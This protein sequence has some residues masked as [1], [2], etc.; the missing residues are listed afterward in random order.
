MPLSDL[1]Q[2]VGKHSVIQLSAALLKR[3]VLNNEAG[4]K[5]NPET[6][7]Y[8]IIFSLFYGVENDE[9]QVIAKSL[10][11]KEGSLQKLILKFLIEVLNGGN[12][13]ILQ[14]CNV[15]IGKV[16]ENKYSGAVDNSRAKS[17][18]GDLL[19][20][21][22]LDL[23]SSEKQKTSPILGDNLISNLT[24]DKTQ[25]F[26]LT[27]VK[28]FAHSYEFIDIDFRLSN[29]DLQ[30]Y[31]TMAT[32]LAQY[33]EYSNLSL[34][35]SDKK[36][37]KDQTFKEAYFEHMRFV[38]R[39]TNEVYTIIETDESTLGPSDLSL[40]RFFYIS[41]FL[42]QTEY[43]RSISL[44]FTSSSVF[45][46]EILNKDQMFDILINERVKQ[47]LKKIDPP[48]DTVWNKINTFFNPLL[49]AKEKFG[50]IVPWLT[51]NLILILVLTLNYNNLNII[52]YFD[53]IVFGLHI[54]VIGVTIYLFFSLG[55]LLFHSFGSF[56]RTKD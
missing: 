46:K 28:I 33:L 18:I 49:F 6:A 54:P 42:N 23:L 29:P 44:N 51:W 39:L 7:L 37:R 21:S 22:L 56:K 52:P 53:H 10:Q 4:S 24:K 20:V 19:L 25:D 31:K 1:D 45:F 15:E 35:M 38:A 11:T 27:F 3:Y 47:R 9:L 32:A 48:S 43:D 17:L 36:G 41:S 12:K 40:S 14:S 16:L 55:L 13:D 2:I 34:L 8:G 50:F 5:I 26:L 30:K